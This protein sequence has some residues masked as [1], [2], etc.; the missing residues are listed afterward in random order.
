MSIYPNVPAHATKDFY[1]MFEPVEYWEVEC[2]CKFVE[3]EIETC[4][5]CKQN[6]EITEHDLENLREIRD[7]MGKYDDG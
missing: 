6:F 5:S 2:K 1:E 3:G 7:A 4:E